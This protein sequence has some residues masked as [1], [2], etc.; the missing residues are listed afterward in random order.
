MCFSRIYR[1]SRIIS[2]IILIGGVKY[3]QQNQK[4]F[5]Q[6]NGQNQEENPLNK[7]WLKKATKNPKYSYGEVIVEWKQKKDIDAK[8]NVCNG[9]FVYISFFCIK[10]IICLKKNKEE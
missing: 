3:H 4:T 5:I 9:G 6:L 1:L 10:R 8:K 2:L 7:L